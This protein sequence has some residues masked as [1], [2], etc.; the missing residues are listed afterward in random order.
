[1]NNFVI[2]I[3]NLNKKYEIR[4]SREKRFL[5]SEV[6]SRLKNKKKDRIQAADSINLTIQK[7]EFV[8]IIG[9]NGVGKSTLLKILSGIVIPD[10]GTVKVEGIVAPLL[11]LMIGMQ[12]YLSG[13]ENIYLY[14]SMLGMTRK[15]IN[16][17]FNKIV[18]FAEMERFIDEELRNYSSG[19]QL[20]LA[21]SITI[22]SNATI[23]LIDEVLAVGDE[24]FQKKCLKRMLEMNDEGKTIL[25]VSHEMDLVINYCDRV[26]YLNQG[27]IIMDG[28][29][30]KVVSRYLN[31]SR[32]R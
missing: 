19:M 4:H 26:L 23:F 22:H 30:R 5:K 27:K 10:S 12:L 6:I 21:F 8:G 14:G 31:D 24:R 1:M 16:G 13:R 18:E 3:K 20:R 2:R 32:N 7:G 11:E 28:K 9:P 25:F 17:V 29:P 15:Q